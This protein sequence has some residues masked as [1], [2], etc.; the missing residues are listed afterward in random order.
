MSSSRYLVKQA[1]ILDPRSSHHGQVRDLIL[2]HGQIVDIAERLEDAQAERIEVE[3]LHLSPG[4]IELRANFNDPGNE[5]REDIESGAQA[6]VNGGFTAVA[7]SPQTLPSVDRKSAVEYLKRRSESSPVHLLPIGSFSKELKGDDLAEMADMKASGALAFSHGTKVVSNAALMRLALLYNRELG[8]PLQV[9]SY[10]EAMVQGGQMHEGAKSTWL[11]LK[12]LPALAEQIG[13]ARDLALAEYTNAPIHFQG[14]SSSDALGLI[15]EAKERGLS[16]SADVNWLNLLKTDA[17]LES[18]DTNLKVYPPLRD[19]AHRLALI[20]GLK[21][22][23]INAIAGDHRPRTIEEKRCEFDLAAF[24][25]A[26]LEISFAA[27]HTALAED[28]GLEHL[29]ERLSRGPREVLNYGLEDRIEKG[30]QLDL[31]FFNPNESWNWDPAKSKSKAANYPYQQ[32][33]FKGK[34]VATYCKGKWQTNSL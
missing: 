32:Q 24:G 30:A 20:E 6:A 31:S 5:D 15:K 22:G 10:D 21:S 3:G 19:E 34:I 26:S 23:L 13:I 25:A 8:S 12:G 11:G 7:L 9:L 29:V 16:L 17:D 27:L 1:R 28:L 4:F 18:Y 2:E 33:E 14:L